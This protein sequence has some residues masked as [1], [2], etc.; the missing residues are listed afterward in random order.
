M[1]R[2]LTRRSLLQ[3]TSALPALAAGTAPAGLPPWSG[4]VASAWADASKA[5][6]V[7]DMSLCQPA[8]ALSAKARRA[9]WKVVPYEAGTLKGN[10]IW[11]SVETEAPPVRLPLGVQGWHAIF[12]GL[13][14][15]EG[16]CLPKVW[17]KLDNDRA[18]LLCEVSGRGI[19]IEEVFF[20]VADVKGEAL[21]IGQQSAGFSA[22][23]GL[24]YVKLIPL[25]GAEVTGLR[26]DRQ[27]AGRRRLAATID[28]FSFIFFRKPTTEEELLAEVERYRD[29]DFGTLLLH[30]GGADWV[31]YP[32]RVG[33]MPGQDLEDFPRTGDRYYAEAVRELARKG[34]NPT[35]VL[36]AGAHDVGMKVH[37]G[38]RPAGWSFFEP[39][40]DMFSSRFYH[41]HP[42]WRSID[43]DGTPVS[44][45][46]WAV[47]EVRAHLIAL[48][49]EAVELGADGAHIVFNRGYPLVLYEPPV[50]E[51]FRKQHGVDPR[52]L[53]E[54]KDPRVRR[55]WSD[56][57]TSFLRE[58]RA[59]LDDVQTR[60]AGGKR[61]ELSVMVLGNESD[62]L[63]YGGDV[64]RWVEEGLM[65]Q[66]YSYK[67]DFGA[68]K[69]VDDIPFFTGICR[70]RKV[71]FYPSFTVD[72]PGYANPLQDAVSWYEQG[73]DGLTFF[74]ANGMKPAHWAV[75]SR[76]GHVE[77]LQERARHAA[78]V[79][80]RPVQSRFHRLGGKV[81]DGRF[82]PYWGG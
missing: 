39:I 47:P 53:D 32:S 40:S 56:V 75:F 48:L 10:M 55:L 43:R 24:V 29:T 35:K 30:M 78:P 34:I 74:D 37:V 49:R 45:M 11:A 21:R 71:S 80:A 13:K 7:A 22:P 25:T 58:T 61:L 57:V 17:L 81:M 66:I 44:R 12:V 52:N 28:G 27:Q 70:P 33:T 68:K 51:L 18:P 73:V 64:R 1:A 31:N 15:D 36:I 63:R 50:V 65:D 76:A 23:A 8:S 38:I 9:H 46:S 5:V 82:P 14:N 2:R 26:A 67:W 16:E 59:M 72:P 69:R 4:T 54:E 60:R 42:E 41:E 3:S 62:N 19:G 20:K 6:V 77:E 79:P